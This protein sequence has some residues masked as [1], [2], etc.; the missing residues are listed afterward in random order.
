MRTNAIRWFILLVTAAAVY[1]NEGGVRGQYEEYN[2]G[3]ENPTSTIAGRKVGT[4]EQNEQR[5]PRIL[6]DGGGERVLVVSE[7]DPTKCVGKKLEY[8]DC[9]KYEKDTDMVWRTDSF[10][11]GSEVRN[12]AS[13]RVYD[14]TWN[15]GIVEGENCL[16]LTEY[17]HGDKH[18]GPLFEF[19]RCESDEVRMAFLLVPVDEYN[20]P[21]KKPKDVETDDYVQ[22][23]VQSTKCLQAWNYAE[24]EL[25]EC[26][27]EQYDIDDEQLWYVDESAGNGSFK[28]RSKLDL[29]MCLDF[30]FYEDP[31]DRNGDGYRVPRLA[32]C[33]DSSVGSRQE[34][35][36]SA[37]GN[38]EISHKKVPGYTGMGSSFCIN[39]EKICRYD[40]DT[41]EEDY[42]WRHEIRITGC[43]G[44][45]DQSWKVIKNDKCSREEA[46]RPS[47]P[48][49]DYFLFVSKEDPDRCWERE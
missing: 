39:S 35:R 13:G 33:D 27:T 43:D 6:G 25:R 28:L 17:W 18:V 3:D 36:Y 2:N 19:D 24:V 8:K 11:G 45:A 10:E 40:D 44:S 47:Y 29:T 30:G 31:W 46:P 37:K 34:W 42:E 48:K 20:G 32:R 9:D 16:K 1:G 49:H 26:S 15:R 4:N 41:C 12:P 5:Q 7:Y 38:K 14:Y 23:Q 22:L 21:P